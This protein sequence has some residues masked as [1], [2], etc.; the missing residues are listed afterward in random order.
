MP[1][2]SL[3][4]LD[5]SRLLPGPY[6]SM[7]FSDFGAEV[8][9]IEEPNLGDYVR[10]NDTKV[11]ENSAVFHSL[12]RNKKSVTLNL[13]TEKGKEVFRKLVETSDIVLESF[14][15]GVMDRLGLGYEDLKKINPGIIY[16][17]ITGYGQDGPYSQMPGHDINYQSYAGLLGLQGHIEGP[18]VLSAIQIADIGGGSQMAT[19]GILIALQARNLT[20]EGQ[21]VDIAMRDGVMSWMQSMYPDYFVNNKVLEKGKLRLGGGKACYYA[22]ETADGRYLSVGA[23]EEKFWKVFCTEIEAKHLIEK[24]NAPFEVQMQMKAEIA[25]IIKKK[26]L[27]EW[28]AIFE[29]KD[30]CVSPIL[31]IDEV[32]QDP[33]VKARNMV[34]EKDGEKYLGFPIKLSKTPGEVKKSAPNLGEDNQDIL[35]ELGYSAEEIEAWKKDGIL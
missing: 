27:E 10:W 23:L 8:I 4:I 20:G 18:P 9:K 34:I 19:I 7:F 29:G 6:C 25:A 28:N 14:R 13:K 16:C 35:T 24:L 11:G 31:N 12:N 3:R 33:Q 17:A 2:S 5:L 22:Y 21:F 30:A 1:L 15:P 32:V 26:T